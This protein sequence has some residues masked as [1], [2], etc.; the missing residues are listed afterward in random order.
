M[1]ALGSITASD[2]DIDIAFGMFGFDTFEIF[3]LDETYYTIDVKLVLFSDGGST[4]TQ[5]YTIKDLS[6]AVMPCN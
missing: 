3:S 6:Y 2:Y 1:R 5:N 4:S